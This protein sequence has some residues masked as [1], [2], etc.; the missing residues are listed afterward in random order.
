VYYEHRLG[1]KPP[2]EQTLPR[3]TLE[4]LVQLD[5]HKEAVLRERYG[6]AVTAEM[7]S[8]EVQRINTTTRAPEMLAEIKT[9]LGNDSEKFA[10]VFAKPL[11]VERLLRAK[12]D[13]DD[14]LHAGIRRECEQA[15]HT[16]LAA[17]TNGADATQL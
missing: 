2:F 1:T 17:K 9:A 5:L 14:A 3:D 12:F 15:R 11:L 7:L 13:N 4:R 10:N 6:I 16:L 8:T